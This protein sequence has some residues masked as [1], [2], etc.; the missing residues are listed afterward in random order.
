MLRISHTFAASLIALGTLVG[1]LA[2]AAELPS[3]NDEAVLAARKTLKV[4]KGETLVFF[5]DLHCATCAK[6]VTGRLFKVK[7]VMRV[8]TNVKLDVAVV[9]PQAK[10]PFDAETAWKALQEAGYQPTRLDG[11]AGVYLADAETKAPVRVA[12]AAG[13]LLR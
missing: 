6:K 5:E 7:G 9:T 11:P 8:R 4:A 1:S 2:V 12:D 10:K 3:P 13:P